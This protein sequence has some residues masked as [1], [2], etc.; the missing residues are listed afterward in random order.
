[1]RRMVMRDAVS[2]GILLAIT[3]ALFAVTGLYYSAYT[4]YR[5]GL[6]LPVDNTPV[7]TLPQ[8]RRHR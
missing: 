4:H 5:A 8:V 7:I 1:M 3:L 2:L 6:G